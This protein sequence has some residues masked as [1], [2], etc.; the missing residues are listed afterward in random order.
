MPQSRSAP[1]WLVSVLCVAVGL[2]AYYFLFDRP[3]QKRLL[4][5]LED[6]QQAIAAKQAEIEARQKT[7][8]DETIAHTRQAMKDAERE[9]LDQLKAKALR[10][11][12]LLAAHTAVQ[13]LKVQYAEYH[14]EH[15]RL[16]GALAD[17]GLPPHWT[18]SPKVQAVHLSS[19]DVRIVLDN[20]HIRGSLV[21]AVRLHQGAYPDWQCHSP[22]IADIDDFLP[23]C[24]YT[25]G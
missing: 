8:V 23:A 3:A 20:E 14:A 22:D 11:E 15:G 1:I 6:K 24:R 19:Q 21:Y 5:A 25:G 18:P 13:A 2:G 17:I 16:P 4:A 9:R 7:A 12:S 10:S